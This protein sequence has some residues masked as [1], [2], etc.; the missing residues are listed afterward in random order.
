[1]HLCK[2]YCIFAPA[3]PRRGSAY[4][5][6]GVCRHIKKA[7]ITLCSDLLESRKFQEIQDLATIDALRDI[8]YPSCAY[9]GTSFAYMHIRTRV[10]KPK[11][12]TRV[13]YIRRGLRVVGSSISGNAK[14][15]RCGTTAV[16]I[17][18]FFVF[19]CEINII[20]N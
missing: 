10:P 11:F 5:S 6:V 2:N 13:F 4:L 18:V 12:S 3:I 14:A 9:Y 8:E 1:M 7:F 15:S 20:N 17:H 19:I 16:G